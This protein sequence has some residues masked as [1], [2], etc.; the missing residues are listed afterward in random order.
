[1][2]NPSKS[3]LLS[4]ID[5]SVS[6]AEFDHLIRSLVKYDTNGFLERLWNQV[7]LIFMCHLNAIEVKRVKNNGLQVHASSLYLKSRTLCEVP[8]KAH[9]GTPILPYFNVVLSIF[10][11]N[12]TSWKKLV[13]T[14]SRKDW[15]QDLRAKKLFVTLIKVRLYVPFFNLLIWVFFWSME[16][17]FWML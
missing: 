7:I 8:E 4:I 3:I 1:M 9:F 12:K 16:R 2:R 15:K 13:Q 6:S 11:T 10:P 17:E 14:V 5:I